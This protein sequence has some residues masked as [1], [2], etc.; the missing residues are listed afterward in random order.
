MKQRPGPFPPGKI[1]DMTGWTFSRLTVLFK[2]TNAW[3]GHPIWCTW[4]ECGTLHLV[5]GGNLR[6]GRTNSCGCLYEERRGY[7]NLSHGMSDHPLYNTWLTMNQKTSSPHHPQYYCNGGIGIGVCEAWQRPM[8]LKQFVK[9]MAPRPSR[10]HFLTL[11]DMTKDYSPDNCLWSP[12]GS[13]L[14]KRQF[15]KMITWRGETHN[16]HEWGKKLNIPKKTLAYRVA[17]WDLDRAFTQPLRD[18]DR[19]GMPRKSLPALGLLQ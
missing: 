1:V 15:G 11:L 7:G 8:G 10:K 17:N 12:A 19:K 13:D 6:S 2:M 4:C 14:R 9:D 18:W 3:D 16:L 5:R